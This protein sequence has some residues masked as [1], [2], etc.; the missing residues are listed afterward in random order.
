MKSPETAPKQR[1]RNWIAGV[2]L[3]AIA[4]GVP[5]ASHKNTVE[6]SPERGV[7]DNGTS[8]AALAS[9]IASMAE[10]AAALPADPF[11]R[12]KSVVL[13]PGDLHVMTIKTEAPVYWEESLQ[14]PPLGAKGNYDVRLKYL[15]SVANACTIESVAIE[16]ALRGNG[17]NQTMYSASLVKV[18]APDSWSVVVTNSAAQNWS[19]IGTSQP[20]PDVLYDDATQTL[21]L[22]VD[23]AASVLHDAADGAPL[24]VL[25]KPTK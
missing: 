23:Q 7:K 3:A 10:F 6:G 21:G 11:R 25:P 16:T 2:V 4:I 24:S 13:R 8:A 15:G 5:L 1:G 18:P 12:Q 20:T 19:V 17:R 9:K 22:A 14:L